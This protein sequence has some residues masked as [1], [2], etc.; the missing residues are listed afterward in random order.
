MNDL[1][2]LGAVDGLLGVIDGLYELSHTADVV[3]D[4][5]SQ[6]AADI[7]SS[8]DASDA[9]LLIE[10][11]EKIIYDSKGISEAMNNLAATINA[12][13][14]ENGI[15]DLSNLDGVI[16]ALGGF[17]VTAVDA[18]ASG[19]SSGS[20]AQPSEIL[21]EMIEAKKGLTASLESLNPNSISG[22]IL[23]VAIKITGLTESLFGVYDS[24]KRLT[25]DT[26]DNINIVDADT[27]AI[28]SGYLSKFDTYAD[29]EADMAALLDSFKQP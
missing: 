26:R 6:L 5:E 29:M 4:L 12:I 28:L 11:F 10:N 1:F 24:Q 15:M 21:D 8:N 9:S 16:D 20:S 14:N 23:G 19:I 3:S 25:A 27:A 13:T 7:R 2:E 17:T 18:K 22:F